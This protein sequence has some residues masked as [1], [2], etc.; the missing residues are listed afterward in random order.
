MPQ[1]WWILLAAIYKHGEINSKTALTLMGEYM[2]QLMSG[3]D[4]KA[5]GYSMRG[6]LSAS[7]KSKLLNNKNKNGTK[8][9]LYSIS[10]AG[11]KL[12]QDYTN[13]LENGVNPESY[14]SKIII[15]GT[16]LMP[17]EPKQQ[18]RFTVPENPL[19]FIPVC[20]RKTP[21]AAHLYGVTA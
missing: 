16:D 1:S 21:A 8:P 11:F 10:D 19:S 17:E 9:G 6:I 5:Q 7:T 4:E 15:I 14:Y 3:M 18:R 12:L 20:P 2:P 13:A